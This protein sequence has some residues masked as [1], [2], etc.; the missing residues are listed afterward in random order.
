MDPYIYLLLLVAFALFNGLLQWIA[1]KLKEHEA[2]SKAAQE[3]DAAAK[4]IQERSAATKVARARDA[5]AKSVQ[6][7]QSAMK[8]PREHAAANRATT[9]DR[10]LDG[11]AA[12]AVRLPER[13][14]P[15][16]RTRPERPGH[17]AERQGQAERAPA[18]RLHRAVTASEVRARLAN[19]EA[20]RQ[21]IVLR[22]VLGPCRGNAPHET[23]R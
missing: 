21:A 22:T 9:G 11:P 5:A 1:R 12:R 23:A 18:R 20:A 3:R 19:R 17:Q 14:D 8:S 7:R 16:E 15:A 2:A 6:R 4:T 10:P 13:R